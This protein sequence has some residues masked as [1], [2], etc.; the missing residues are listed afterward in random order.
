MRRL[1]ILL[2]ILVL[3]GSIITGCTPMIPP[4]PTVTTIVAPDR[5]MSSAEIEQLYPHIKP[6]D[7]ASKA[8][9]VA[10]LSNGGNVTGGMVTLSFDDTLESAYTVAKPILDLYGYKAVEAVVTDNVGK[11][12]YLTIDE[13]KTMQDAGWDIVSHSMTHTYDLKSYQVV[14]NEVLNSQEWLLAHGFSRANSCYI[15]P[16]AVFNSLVEEVADKYYYLIRSAEN[17]APELLPKDYYYPVQYS[18]SLSS[19]Y[20]A[21]DNKTVN[22][23]PRLTDV[24][25]QAK[26]KGVWVQLTFHDIVISQSQNPQ[27]QLNYLVDVMTLLKQLGIPVV[28]YSDILRRFGN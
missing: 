21:T 26:S 7:E 23:I 17:L 12:P 11:G 25:N 27:T 4:A 28:T 3:G 19:V 10:W 2:V 22:F 24:L 9:L 20:S 1:I 15:L 5:E 13:L 6:V 8:K 16:G 18:F 14:E